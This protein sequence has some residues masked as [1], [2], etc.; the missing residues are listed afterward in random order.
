M[1]T[2][3]VTHRSV[4]ELYREIEVVFIVHDEQRPQH[5]APPIIRWNCHIKSDRIRSVPFTRAQNA[6]YRRRAKPG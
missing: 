5:D 3:G 4:W 6:V 2:S 1:E